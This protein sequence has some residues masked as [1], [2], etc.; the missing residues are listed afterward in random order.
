MLILVPMV[1]YR[2]PLIVRLDTARPTGSINRSN[3]HRLIG[4][5]RTALQPVI[6]DGRAVPRIFPPQQTFLRFR[7]RDGC[8]GR[9]RRADAA[10]VPPREDK[11]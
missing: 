1:L 3:L 11:R 5:E 6:K 7:V 9:H 10:T 2:A 8:L 4:G